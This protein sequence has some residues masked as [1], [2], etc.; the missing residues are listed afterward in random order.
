MGNPMPVPVG[1]GSK[2]RILNICSACSAANPEA[3]FLSLTE[4]SILAVFG[5]LR[6]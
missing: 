2:E 1:L 4:T 6:F 5:L 3:G